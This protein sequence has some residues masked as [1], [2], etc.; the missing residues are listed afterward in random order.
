[1]TAT[2]RSEKVSPYE[3]VGEEMTLVEHLAELR[4]RLVRS[5]L[6]IVAGFAVGFVF[7]QRILDLLTRPYCSLP[8]EIRRGAT[9]LSG[10]AECS[11]IALRV[12]DGFVISLKA[13]AIVAIVLAGPV[14]CYQI[15]RFI[16]PGLR[17]IERRYAIPFIVA[18]QL[19][20]AAGAVFSYVLIPKALE[21]LLGFA[22]PSLTPVL[23]GNEYLSFILHAMLAFG[24]AF[25]FPLVLMIL[26]LMGIVTAAGLRGAWRYAVF[27]IFVGAAVLTP[28]VDPVSMT[29][30]AAPLI[31]FYEISIWFAWFVERRRR[32]QEH[33][34]L[35][36]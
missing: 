12:T 9:A 15:L 36:A 31:L 18:S 14:V 27:G 6:A 24:V 16:M 23:A 26:S 17:P 33:A 34:T 25:E 5:A 32:V 22:G 2:A 28:Q 1:M 7:H 29:A 3:Y 11:L 10:S 4:T 13:S 8:A 21:F 35:P 20:F 19:L 30:M